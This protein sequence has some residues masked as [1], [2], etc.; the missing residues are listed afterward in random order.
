MV[1]PEFAAELI[2]SLYEEAVV[3]PLCD[4]RHSDKPADVH[5]PA[6]DETSRADGSRWG[7]TLSY[8][9]AEGVTPPEALP[10]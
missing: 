3:A 8:W 6:I 2:G 10:R 1:E 4:R 7:G 9:E 5:L